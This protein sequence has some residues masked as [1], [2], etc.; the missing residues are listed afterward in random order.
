MNIDDVRLEASG[1]T[2]KVYAGR[3]TRDGLGWLEK[4]D[5][6]NDFVHAVIT[7]WNGKP[8]RVARYDGTQFEITV[9]QIH[10]GD[11]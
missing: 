1:A 10:G 9:R 8:E 7:R 11:R 5:V 6:T 2:G 3:I 4:K